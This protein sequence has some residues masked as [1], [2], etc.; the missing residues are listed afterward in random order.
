MKPID[1]SVF[2]HETALCDPNLVVIAQWQRALKAVIADPM[3][4]QEALLTCGYTEPTW[5]TKEGKLVAMLTVMIEAARFEGQEDSPLHSKLLT[6]LQ[7]LEEAFPVL[8]MPL[9]PTQR[10]GPYT[11]DMVRPEEK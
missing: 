1:M 7:Q 11:E 2:Y 3:V 10:S 4:L 8:Q 5:K 6:E 9:S